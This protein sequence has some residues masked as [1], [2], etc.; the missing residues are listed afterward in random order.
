[1]ECKLKEV[2]KHCLCSP[3]QY[4]SINTSLPICNGFDGCYEKVLADVKIEDNCYPKCP[5]DCNMVR[6]SL[7]V[8]T[9]QLDIK[10]ICSKDHVEG[11]VKHELGTLFANDEKG[12]PPKFIRHFQQMKYGKDIGVEK[13][14]EERLQNVA[15]IR[16]HISGTLFER[17]KR[18]KRVR[19]TDHFSNIGEIFN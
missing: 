12:Y 11:S 10:K 18:T 5:I 2:E 8:T 3:W 17:I 7:M 4:P 13:I 9:K 6:Y 15:M 19:L 1:M 14:C 16:M